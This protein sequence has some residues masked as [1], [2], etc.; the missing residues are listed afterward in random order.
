M[1]HLLRIIMIHGHL[2]GIVELALDGHTNIC[3]TNA[4]GKTTLQRLI[5][6]FY[7]ER[8]NNVVPKTRKKFDQYYL[9]HSNAYLI[10][11]YRR[12]AGTVCHVAITRKKDDGVSYR[13]IN[14]A[15]SP[16]LYLSSD[17]Q[18]KLQAYSYQE[19]TAGLR[20]RGID[21]SHRI[22]TIS[23][24]R[25]IIQNDFSL[26]TG[27]LP[28]AEST[29]LRQTALRYSLAESP[30]R[31]RHIEKLVSAVHA[32]EGKM[33][34]LKT[35]L[36]AIF[37]DE[38]VA[39]PTTRIKG[40]Q[41]REWVQQVRQSRRLSGLKNDIVGL[42][43][44][45]DTLN[46]TEQ[47]LWQLQPLL[48][49]DANELERQCADQDAE[50]KKSKRDLALQEEQYENQRHTLNSQHSQ[51]S[52]DL[53]Q[54]EVDLNDIELRHE[55]FIQADMQGLEQAVN[56]LPEWR[57]KRDELA[58]HLQLLREAEGGSRQRFESRK[59]ELSEQLNEFVEKVS[60]QQQKI[61]NDE[62][63]LR[64]QQAQQQRLLEQEH[65]QQRQLLQD[66]FQN[67]HTTIIE[68]QADVK[69]RLAVGLLTTE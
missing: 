29:R 22:D 4:S 32:K 21:S 14:A 5:P 62:Q 55:T 57:A 50:I 69:A 16:E 33:D 60:H 39:L 49:K 43:K 68:Q 48:L 66:E 18:D 12:E 31:L 46:A 8:P 20:Q 17:A 52:S 1:S 64:S 40:A 59:L 2:D 25:S 44:Q 53:A 61:R 13:F 67:K 41:V 58:T 23:E 27:S 10:Y 7:G 3:G 54:V 45:V 35:M 42:S 30:H 9:P 36:A 26:L 6:V 24:Y 56:Q 38:G 19:F 11:E 37:E 34:T 65:Q 51:V 28:R 47:T 15:Y 63:E